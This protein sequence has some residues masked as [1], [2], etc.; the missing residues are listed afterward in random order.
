MY[1]TTVINKTYDR[2]F[3]ETWEAIEDDVEKVISKI[4]TG[5]MIRAMVTKR[6]Q[7]VAES[8][9]VITTTGAEEDL[10]HHPLTQTPPQNDWTH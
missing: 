7:E 2:G 3:Y 8:Y 5:A 6:E 9:G 10:C 1:Q 4:N